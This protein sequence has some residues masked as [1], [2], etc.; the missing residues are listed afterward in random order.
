ML[1]FFSGQLPPA[2]VGSLGLG[3]L[4]P[5][6]DTTDKKD[7]LPAMMRV[8][9]RLWCHESSRVFADRIINDDGQ[10]TA[11]KLTLAVHVHT[12]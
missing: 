8:I 1:G 5:P 7:T 4:A 11:Y 9:A 10:L 12:P 2:S 3:S 6:P